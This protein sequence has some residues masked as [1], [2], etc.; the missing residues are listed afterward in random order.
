[1]REHLGLAK[2]IYVATASGGHF[3][4]KPDSK[5]PGTFPWERTDLVDKLKSVLSK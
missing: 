5:G 3:G 2:P 4:R 1:M